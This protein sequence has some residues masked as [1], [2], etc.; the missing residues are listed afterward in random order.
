MSSARSFVHVAV[1]AVFTAALPAYASGE[2]WRYPEKDT[3]VKGPALVEIGK[4]GR[5]AAPKIDVVVRDGD[6][7]PVAGFAV[8]VSPTFGKKE[9]APIGAATGPDGVV[10]VKGI[11][12]SGLRALRVALTWGGGPKTIRARLEP[13]GGVWNLVAAPYRRVDDGK[14]AGS[15]RNL[16]TLK[17]AGAGSYALIFKRPPSL[18]WCEKVVYG[19]DKHAGEFTRLDAIGARNVNKGDRN[20]FSPDD[21]VKMGLEAS[22]QYDQKLPPVNDPEI[23]SYVTRLAETVVAAS[24]QPKTELHVRVVNTEDV[25]AFVTAGGHVYVFTGLIK[26]T[27]NESQLAGVMAHEISH[28]IARHVTEGAT[29]NTMAQTG[30]QLGSAILGS[31]LGLGND[32]QDLVT[33]GA[34]TSAGLITLKYDRGSEAEADLL[35]AQYLWKAGW[36]PEAIARFFELF[37]KMGKTA[38]VP[39]WLSTHP[40]DAKRVQNGIA[41]ARAFLP[42]KDRYLVDTAEFQAVKAKVAKLPPSKAAPSTSPSSG[43]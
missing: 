22:T 30:A 34:T 28:A 32:A 31:L 19:S 40:S 39:Q 43:R 37:Q 36:D 3:P 2:V 8:S 26:T 18:A 6:G 15:C 41:W 38:S 21:E 17:P 7:K 23:V 35:G 9:S 20:M 5:A 27:Q 13:K 29:R 14:D 25:N 10:V 33:Q 24:D 16:F 1:M 11:D 12:T 42:P 4:P